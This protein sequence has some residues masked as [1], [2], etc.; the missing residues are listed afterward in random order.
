MVVDDLVGRLASRVW[1]GVFLTVV[2]P[3]A[4]EVG[5]VLALVIWRRLVVNGR[6]RSYSGPRKVRSRVGKPR[7]RARCV[8]DRSASAVVDRGVVLLLGLV[9][10]HRCGPLVWMLGAHVYSLPVA[11][12]GHAKIAA[13]AS[14]LR[15]GLFGRHL[16]T[17]VRDIGRV[18]FRRE[19]I[20]DRVVAFDDGRVRRQSLVGDVGRVGLKGPGVVGLVR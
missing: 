17:L 11:G 6:A 4:G 15:F 18:G 9:L 8:C 5:G 2:V 13:T 7:R 14:S 3:A 19:L 12:R 10:A 1:P 20:V 16:A